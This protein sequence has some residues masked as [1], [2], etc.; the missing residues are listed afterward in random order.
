[1][2]S[3]HPY[4]AQ[5]SGPD[6]PFAPGN[7]MT[8]FSAFG[9]A[10]DDSADESAP[11]A[12]AAPVRAAVRM[13]AGL[14]A[15]GPTT[16]APPPEQPSG[17]RVYGRPATSGAVYGAPPAPEPPATYG[18]P[19]SRVYGQPY[20][21]SPS[22]P[23]SAPPVSAP[24]A[25]GPSASGPPARPAVPMQRTSTV[26]GQRQP[27]SDPADAPMSGP[28]SQRAFAGLAPRQ[29]F[30]VAPPRQDFSGPPQVPSR[31]QFEQHGRQTQAPAAPA[32]ADFDRGWP[33]AGRPDAGGSGYRDEPAA[34]STAAP[35]P[36]VRQRATWQEQLQP[37][38][39]M[40]G[41][42]DDLSSPA[43]TPAYVD[44]MPAAPPRSRL[45]VFGYIAIP[46]AIVLLAAGALYYTA[47]PITPQPA[48]GA[49]FI[50]NGAKPVKVSCSTKGAYV[51]VKAVTNASNCPDYLNEPS[52]SYATGGTT[53]IYCL[54]QK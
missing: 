4:P 31:P 23:V 6:A 43:P 27:V 33:D 22:A 25:S 8:P 46:I 19:A 36:P 11:A 1:M 39:A 34:G 29:D 7:E 44:V 49:C 17:G 21:G 42:R 37:M 47:R 24:P 15:N 50:P 9:G 18:T 16:G 38:V 54:Q 52:I 45:R 35:A 30:A 10:R 3:E 40:P 53:T 5:T 32:Q 51:V 48:V 2:T 12:A 28:P 20:A 14:L 13:P 41:Q 26:Y